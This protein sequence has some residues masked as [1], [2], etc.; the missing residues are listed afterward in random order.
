MRG[1]DI[2]ENAAAAEEPCCCH[3]AITGHRHWPL[4]TGHATSSRQL[5]GL[6]SHRLATATAAF[7]ASLRLVAAHEKGWRPTVRCLPR[8]LK[9]CLPGQV[10]RQEGGGQ[11]RRRWQVRRPHRSVWGRQVPCLSVS[12][13]SASCLPPASFLHPT[14]LGHLHQLHHYPLAGSRKAIAGTACP[15]AAT[16]SHAKAGRRRNRR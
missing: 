10:E 4:A 9:A 7:Q 8:R 11:N 3:F 15:P 14:N 2:P 12:L 6:S 16:H 5:P 13:P 1:H